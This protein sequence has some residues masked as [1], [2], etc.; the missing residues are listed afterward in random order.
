MAGANENPLLLRAIALAQSGRVEDAHAL[1]HKITSENPN[2]EMAWLWLVQTEPDHAQRIQILEECL[3][4]NPQSEYARKGLA[5]LRTGPLTGK[6]PSK[7][8]TQ[9]KKRTGPLKRSS[10][11]WKGLLLLA[12]LASGIALIIAGILFYPQWKGFFPSLGLPDNPLAFLQL[13]AGN[14][15]TPTRTLTLVAT[16]TRTATNPAT[17]TK[18]STRTRTFTPS[19]TNTPTVTRTPTLFLG[20]PVKDE[21]VILFLAADRCE[22]MRIPISGGSPESLTANVPADCS[23]PEL[24]PDGQKIVFI[25]LPDKNTLHTMNVSGTG[26]KM[27]TKL[28]AN[29]SAGRTIWSLEWAPGGVAV[30]FVAS[31][32]TKDSQGL[33]RVSDSSGYLYT[34]AMNTGYAKQMK[35]LGVERAYANSISWSPD[36]EWVFSFDMGNPL[37]AVSY[38]FAFRASD[39]RTVWITQED[40]Y[41]GHYDWSPDSLYLSSLSPQKPVTNALPAGDPKDQY[42]IVIYGLDES[43]HYIPLDKKGYATAFG[44]RWFPD[45]S[46][47]LLYD[48]ATR[49]LVAVSKEGSFLNSVAQLEKAPSF[50][51]FSPDGQ[52]IAMIE[53]DPAAETSGTLMIVHPDGKDLR[54]L[55]RGVMPAPLVWR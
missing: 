14:S 30:A 49:K 28:P 27:F 38:P 55:A 42:Y 20:V 39:L 23:Q 48:E 47:F 32:F 8:S 43:K 46:A 44:A 51:S 33:P 29:S 24:S 22:A 37:E 21:P 11:P 1:L 52:W 5:G 13:P 12:A 45:R 15:P 19:L 54:I 6:P 17:P 25:A 18:T 41:L 31:G 53:T 50:L 4:H 26:E 7:Q 34:A 35:A 36:G 9:Q 3:R 10:C 40:P 2:D 16:K